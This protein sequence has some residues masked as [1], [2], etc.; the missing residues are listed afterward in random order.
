MSNYINDT[1]TDLKL[2]D[3]FRSLKEVQIKQKELRYAN[4]SYLNLS[5]NDYLHLSNAAMQREFLSCVIDSPDQLM[6]NPSSRLITG[7]S[8]HYTLLE[9]KL[10]RLYQKEAALVLSSG[11][12]VN[13]GALPAMTSKRDLVVADKLVHASIIEALRLLPCKFERYRHNDMNHLESILS[14]SKGSYESIYI[15][16]E[17]IFSMDGDIAPL[18]E[19][20]ELKEQY[21][22]KLY[23]DEAHAIG[24]RGE[25][26]L[27]LAQEQGVM[28]RVDYIVGT[29]GKS[30]SSQGGFLICDTPTKELMVNRMRTLI[31]STAIPP[32]SLLWSSYMLDRIVEAKEHRAHLAT[33]STMVQESI[34]G[35][36]SAS[37]IIPIITG[38]N[39]S[40]LELAA[41]LR[42]LGYWTTAI[43]YPTVAK[44]SARIRLSLT[45]DITL[46]EINRLIKDLKSSI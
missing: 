4:K 44:G 43:R 42:E 30:L 13:S 18:K 19:L 21:D 15:V 9:D 12:M 16:T 6:S 11:Y 22:A 10:A 27:G 37:N 36:I 23:L 17:S 46:E 41:H 25:Q 35:N 8:S 32:I 39:S 28:D 31:F 3:N 38:S 34:E 20:I 45:A 1:L 7:N 14:S 5:S 29:M 26:G 40:A 2:H 24:T 33:I